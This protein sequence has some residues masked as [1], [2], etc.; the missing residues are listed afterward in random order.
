MKVGNREEPLL[1]LSWMTFVSKLWYHY[2]G[3][4][5][6]LWKISF[7][8]DCMGVCFLYSCNAEPH[9]LHFTDW[10]G[11]SVSYK[12][13][14]SHINFSVPHLDLQLDSLILQVSCCLHWFKSNCDVFKMKRPEA[15]GEWQILLRETDMSEECTR[16]RRWLWP[17]SPWKKWQPHVEQNEKVPSAKAWPYIHRSP[18]QNAYPPVTEPRGS[19][20]EF[21]RENCPA[22][23]Q[24]STTFRKT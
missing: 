1:T 16:R 8:Q 3:W 23:T 22:R 9:W 17:F 24:M 12:E 5:V 7:R 13:N 15:I 21:Q 14:C 20:E 11:F 4:D 10:K 19:S 2:A 18:A 6:C